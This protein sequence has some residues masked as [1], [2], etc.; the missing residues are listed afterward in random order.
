MDEL[1]IVRS[2]AGILKLQHPLHACFCSYMCELVITLRTNLM[3][4]I[5][6]CGDFL[7]LLARVP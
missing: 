7:L 1:G 3:L 4:D 5:L 6:S 2:K